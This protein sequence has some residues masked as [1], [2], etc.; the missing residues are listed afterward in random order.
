MDNFKQYYIGSE[1]EFR[2]DEILLKSL[3][4]QITSYLKESTQERFHSIWNKIF[5]LRKSFDKE[6]FYDIILSEMDTEDRKKFMQF[7]LEE[8]FRIENSDININENPKLW[9]YQLNKIKR[10]TK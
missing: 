9:E 4:R 2:E 8:G 7:I 3:K 5:I 10:R 6:K 1:F